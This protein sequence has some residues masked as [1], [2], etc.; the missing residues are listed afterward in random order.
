MNEHKRTVIKAVT[1]LGEAFRQ[2]ITETTIRAYE[3]GLQDVDPKQI[4]RAVGQA[5][6]QC[7]FMPTVFELRKFCGTISADSRATLA[8]AAA[9]KAVRDLD[10]TKSVDFDDPVINATIRLMG[11]WENFCNI[12]CGEKF[13]VWGR[14]QFEETYL[15]LYNSDLSPDL[16]RPLGGFHET[17]NAA[18]GR[19]TRPSDFVRI[20][21]G[22]P[23]DRKRISGKP[24]D[25]T[26]EKRRLLTAGHRRY[27]EVIFL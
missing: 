17:G 24:S 6:S 7:Q 15:K 10:Y 3:I 20:E 9:K 13:D 12:E 14:K 5:I 8:W 1:I 27:A 21:T 18:H 25:Q 4:E 22:L 23:I 16:T 19:V 11:G 2:K 26:E